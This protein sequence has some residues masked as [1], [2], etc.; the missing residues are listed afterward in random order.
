MS[1]APHLFF[2]YPSVRRFR[3][4]ERVALTLPATLR[5]GRSLVRGHSI[6]VSATG[7]VLQFAEEAKPA[8][9]A[10]RVTSG[11]LLMTVELE[12]PAQGQIITALGRQVWAEPGA[13]AL[14]F[15]KM[16]DADRLSLAELVDGE[17]ALDA[18]EE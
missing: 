8:E 17:R 1:T 7:A 16:A 6:E 9:D 18:S 3:A 10:P 5:R 12:L 4:A 2:T 15:V 14:S 11:P 13:V